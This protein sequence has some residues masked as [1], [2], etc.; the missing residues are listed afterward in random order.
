MRAYINSRGGNDPAISPQFVK[1]QDFL[2]AAMNIQIS[3]RKT[4]KH[5]AVIYLGTSYT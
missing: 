4:I 2:V 1:L 5:S 3:E